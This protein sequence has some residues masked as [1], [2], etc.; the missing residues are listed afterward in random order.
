M[1]AIVVSTLLNL[2]M[3]W[4]LFEADELIRNPVVLDFCR[5][6]ARKALSQRNAEQGAFVV[7]TGDLLYF[8]AWPPGDERDMLRW[9]GRFPE[10]TV[11]IVHTHPAWLP[12]ASRLD[13]RTAHDAK[14]PVYVIT[15][16]RIAKTSGG[17]TEVVMAGDWITAPLR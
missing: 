3:T 17:A 14:I 15:P 8:V 7:K 2:A 5:V 10:G 9:Y 11:A 1:L 4:R 13:A 6:L 16:F 12:E